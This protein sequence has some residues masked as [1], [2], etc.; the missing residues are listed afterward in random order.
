MD[1]DLGIQNNSSNEDGSTELLPD[2]ATQHVMSDDVSVNEQDDEYFEDV[3]DADDFEEQEGNISSADMADGIIAYTEMVN[4]TSRFTPNL[5]KASKKTKKALYKNERIITEY[6]DDTV[7]TEAT[8]RSEDYIELVASARENRIL[9]GTITG[10]RLVGDTDNPAAPI[11]AEVAYGHESFTVC[12]PS[13]VLANYKTE[14]YSTMEERLAIE[15]DIT[16]RI[17][18]KISFVVQYVD[19]AAGIAYADRLAALSM[20]GVKNFLIPQRDGKPRVIVI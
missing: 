14:K 20:I 13:F 4:K 8:R 10:M 11:L 6:G 7:D 18:S 3:D 19:E 5:A 9:Q 2:T 1:K 17:G 15:K 12:I 16:R